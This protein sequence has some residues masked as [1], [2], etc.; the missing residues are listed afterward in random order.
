MP[1][2]L[3]QLRVVCPRQNGS[4][5]RRRNKRSATGIGAKSGESAGERARARVR[6]PAR[7]VLLG[8]TSV[9][10]VRERATV[11]TQLLHPISAESFAPDLGSW[12][13]SPT[14][15]T[16]VAS[17]FVAP[18]SGPRAHI[19]MTILSRECHRRTGTDETFKVPW[20]LE[21]LLLTRALG[22]PTVV[23]CMQAEAKCKRKLL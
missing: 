15:R 18:T 10:V 4:S 5:R 23:L 13:S 22:I 16:R 2:Q 3:L 6:A 9:L 17:Q 20:R 12:C 11:T 21:L 14:T 19:T 8:R 7:Q 1:A